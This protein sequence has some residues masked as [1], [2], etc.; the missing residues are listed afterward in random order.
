M[1]PRLR[2]PPDEDVAQTTPEQVHDNGGSSSNSI[3]G[4]SQ[5][6]YRDLSAKTLAEN[7]YVIELDLSD[8][9]LN[10]TQARENLLYVEVK[11]L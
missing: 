4:P 1:P 3:G 5:D 6:P 7:P 9:K 10:V 8:A 11:A 2:R